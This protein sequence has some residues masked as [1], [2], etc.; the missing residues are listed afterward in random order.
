MRITKIRLG[1]DP[2]GINAAIAESFFAKGLGFMFRKV[3]EDEALL[4]TNCS[5]IHTF[6]ML[7]DIDAVFLDPEFRIIRI[8]SGLK[9][10]RLVSRAPGAKMVLELAGNAAFHLG[11]K[12]GDKIEFEQRTTDEI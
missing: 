12:P 6:F 2:T 4:L 1:G 8:I 5:S 10:W 9:P 3:K 7:S 11:M